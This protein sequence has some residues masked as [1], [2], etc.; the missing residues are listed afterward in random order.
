VRHFFPSGE[1]S[2]DLV[3]LPPILI[4]GATLKKTWEDARHDQG[5]QMVCFQTKNANL[6]KFWRA[7]QWKM[8]VY[9]FYGH[10]V[11]FTVL[12]YILLAFGKVRGKL[13]YFI[14]FWYFVPRKIWQ[15]WTR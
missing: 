2:P 6:D 12:C 5:C 10:L 1:I 15:P 7:L 11:H 13:V 4:F 8:L 3:T 9:V 14:P